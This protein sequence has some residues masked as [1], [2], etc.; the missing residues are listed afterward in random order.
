[1]KKKSKKSIL[2]AMILDKRNVFEILIAAIL[3]FKINKIVF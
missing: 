2:P 1:M 3:I